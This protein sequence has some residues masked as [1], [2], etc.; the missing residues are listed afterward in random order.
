MNAFSNPMSFGRAIHRRQRDDFALLNRRYNDLFSGM[1]VRLNKLCLQLALKDIDGA[2]TGQKIGRLKLLKP[3]SQ[4]S[5]ANATKIKDICSRLSNQ[6][7]IRNSMAHGAMTTGIMNNGDVAFFQK[8]DDAAASNPVY[9]VMSVEDFNGAIQ[10]IITANDLLD[11]ILIQP[12]ALRPPHQ[13]AKSAQTQL[14]E[15]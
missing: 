3:S 8:A 15:Q 14:S 5:K 13:A 2:T 7:T 9:V 1:E 12:T 6:L 11:S 10:A 4:L